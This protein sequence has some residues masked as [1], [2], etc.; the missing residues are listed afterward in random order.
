MAGPGF[1]RIHPCPLT[2]LQ[3]L[4]LS[5]CSPPQPCP[6]GCPRK[7]EFQHPAPLQP[8]VDA[9]LWPR[10]A[11]RT[12]PAGLSALSA[13][14]WWLDSPLSPCSSLLSWTELPAGEGASQGVGTFPLSQLLLRG[15]SPIPIPTPTF[16]FLSS[17]P[18]CGD[19]SY[20][21]GCLRWS[22]S[23]QR[24]FCENYCRWGC[25]LTC[26][27]EEVSCTS[28]CSATLIGAPPPSPG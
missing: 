5:A 24:V 11:V 26:M 22:A 23:M 8:S 17:Y 28:A 9:C 14:G 27:G 15:A 16:F 12:V 18:V 19:F 21:F 7:P 10:V 2:V 3:P 25:V 4:R 13:A 6:S 1:F 20:D